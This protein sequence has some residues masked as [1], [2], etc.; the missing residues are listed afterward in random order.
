M[1]TQ[2]RVRPRRCK[3]PGRSG[4][5]LDNRLLPAGLRRTGGR[6]E[7]LPSR[8]SVSRP[9]ADERVGEVTAVLFENPR[10]ARRPPS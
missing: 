4:L 10:P 8:A 5:A 7:A 3:R 1:G 6:E 2:G 9:H